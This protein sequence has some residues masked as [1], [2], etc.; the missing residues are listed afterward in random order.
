[1]V[2]FSVLRRG[3]AHGLDRQTR[4]SKQC[5]KAVP[6]VHFCR[7]KGLVT[8]TDLQHVA[9]APSCL[10]PLGLLR[11]ASIRSQGKAE[12]PYLSAASRMVSRRFRNKAEPLVERFTDG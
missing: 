12:I 1:M 2:I 3:S 11:I 9:D 6:S 5:S 4:K 10:T 8:F 7:L